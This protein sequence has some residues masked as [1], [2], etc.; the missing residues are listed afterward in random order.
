MTDEH[1]RIV[2]SAKNGR[3]PGTF[4]VDGFVAGIWRADRAKNVAALTLTPFGPLEKRAVRALA[5]EGDALLR[6][7]EDDAAQY[8]L[9]WQPALTG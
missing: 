2:F 7:L 6:F 8:E 9:R 3:I 5:K 4:L 1:R